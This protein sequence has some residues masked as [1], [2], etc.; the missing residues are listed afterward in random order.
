[1]YIFSYLDS[2]NRGSV[3]GIF[4]GSSVPGPRDVRFWT[5][6]SV[7]LESRCLPYRRGQCGRTGGPLD[8]RRS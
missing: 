2:E 7:T 4:K 1:M 8:L 3:E 6:V 5:A